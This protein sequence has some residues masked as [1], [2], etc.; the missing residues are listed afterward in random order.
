MTASAFQF[1]ILYDGT[2]IGSDPCSSKLF[3]NKAGIS[4]LVIDVLVVDTSPIRYYALLSLNMAGQHHY[5]VSSNQ[6]RNGFYF[7][8]SV[9]RVCKTLKR[10]TG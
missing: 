10:V 8:Y 4:C 6:G 7:A 3:A 1:T 2:K 5:A 9:L